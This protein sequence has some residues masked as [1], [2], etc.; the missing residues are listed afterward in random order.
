[1]MSSGSKPGFVREQV[2]RAPRDADL[3]FDRVRLAGFV[4]GHDDHG[5]AVS[6]SEARLA[7]ELRLAF[8]QRHRVDDAAPLD[9]LEAGF[10]DRPLR[11]VEDEGHLADVGLDGKQVQEAGHGRLRVEH[12][13]VHVDVEHLGAA[14]DLLASDL[15]RVTVS[16]FGDQAGEP[17]RPGD[18]GALAD[19]DEE[20]IR[21]DVEGLEARETGAALD[22]RDPAR[23][24]PG[25]GAHDRLD[26][27][28]RGAAA[29]ADDVDR[30][31][32]GEFAKHRGRLGRRVVVA[33]EGVREA[34][35]GVHADRQ[36]GD[37][38]QLL[39]VRPQQPGTERA[40][41]P[42]D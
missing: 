21:P 30:A 35:V 11:R 23:P 3:A 37:A 28:G 5:R 41:Q 10:D 15:H 4:E 22:R 6:P 19:V 9:A 32:V 26:V 18:V 14:L 25:D 38:R 24:L 42:D 20:R 7:Q 1:M 17:A 40:V 13:F 34:G 16:A 33:A 12:A 2:E 31:L 8:L 36:V 29:A 27:L 39:D